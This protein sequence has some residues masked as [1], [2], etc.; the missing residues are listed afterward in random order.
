MAR[1]VA[2]PESKIRRRRKVRR[3]RLAIILAV[4]FLILAGAAVGSTW[5]PYIRIAQMNVS[6]TKEVA[7]SSI[8]A[9][10]SDTLSARKLFVF[11]SDN[12]FIY[13]KGAIEA[14]LLKNFP[15]LASA[16]VKAQNF[17]AIDISVT[18]RQTAALWC[19]EDPTTGVPCLRMD[20]NGF[21]FAPAAE[22]SDGAYI[23]YYGSATSTP[24]FSGN[25]KQFLTPADFRALTPLVQAIAKNQQ[26]SEVSNVTVDAQND[27][28][29]LFANGFSV[30]FALSDAGG[31]AYERFTLA[32][33][34][35]PFKQHPISDF[36][37]LDLRFG[38]KLY[39]HLKR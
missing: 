33:Q 20:E 6:G 35:D 19:G 12:I 17:T 22:F 7:T 32:L 15:M 5:L 31:D 34:S 3:I 13:P 21:A 23:S 26:G 38:D 8:E 39:Y 16:E 2:L 25:P 29:L 28:H 24:G 11:P 4:L 1:R 36:E 37:Y 14:G 10:V 27:V 30:I 18:E 9:Y